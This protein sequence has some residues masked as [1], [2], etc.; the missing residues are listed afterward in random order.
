MSS[1]DQSRLRRPILVANAEGQLIYMNN[2][3]YTLLEVQSDEIIHKTMTDTPIPPSIIEAYELAIKRR[4]KIENAEVLIPKKKQEID[5]AEKAEK[6][7]LDVDEEE[8]EAHAEEEGE[9]EKEEEIEYVFQGYANV[10]PIRGKESSLD[11]YL[12]V[13]SDHIFGQ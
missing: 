3:L 9:K 5:L 8:A 1:L 11:Y 4:S 13:L 2:Q 12:M 10:L 7:K 6:D